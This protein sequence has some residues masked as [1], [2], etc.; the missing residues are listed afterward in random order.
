MIYTWYAA[1]LSLT[2]GILGINKND[3]IPL[4]AGSFRSHITAQF[5]APKLF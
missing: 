3:A 1:K 2:F 4:F 5:T